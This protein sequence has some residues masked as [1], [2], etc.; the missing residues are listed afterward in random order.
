[1]S[2]TETTVEVQAAAEVLEQLGTIRTGIHTGVMTER[3]RQVLEALMGRYARAASAARRVSPVLLPSFPGDDDLGDG[4]V[5][6]D[7][8]EAQRY[9]LA[10]GDAI[11]DAVVLAGRCGSDEHAG[12]VMRGLEYLLTMQQ[13]TG[14][15]LV[16]ADLAVAAA[17]RRGDKR[18][19]AHALLSR[20]G[21]YKVAGQPVQA[22]ADYEVA[23]RLFA[24]LADAAGTVAVLSR[25]G[26][27]YAAARKLDAADAAF[28][29]MLALC[30]SE[31]VHR[32]MAYVN[33]AW[34]AIERGEPHSAIEQGLIGLDLLQGC[35]GAQYWS[36]EAHLELCRAYT[37][38]GDLDQA[39]DHLNA[40]LASF[41]AGFEPAPLRVFAALVKG[42]L[43]LVQGE[44][45][46]ALVMFQQAVMLQSAGTHPY[47]LA[48]ALDGV[49]KALSRL[50][51]DG[52]AAEQHS[53]A[54]AE[55]LRFGE[56]FATA[57]TRYYLARAKAAS[58][59]GDAGAEQRDQAL[60]E[61]AGLVD[62]AADTLRADLKRLAL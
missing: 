62:P 22:V 46:D 42:E 47:R 6:V 21:G 4:P 43:L 55:R 19:E 38:I 51:E 37:L 39:Q 14:R 24:E 27:A 17:R 31:D 15:W 28:S 16:L 7:L 9:Y 36:L 26:V 29:Q 44:Y 11:E 1:M 59:Q 41:A 53:A 58:G 35:D 18:A 50:G 25:L 5:F 57:R 32:A 52:Q 3:A 13:H 60:L 61:L 20:G 34:V 48:D 12:R 30:T 56:P 40:A 2:N 8:A 33:R 45:R 49:G 10:H 23:V 54:L